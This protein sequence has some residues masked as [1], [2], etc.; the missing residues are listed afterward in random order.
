M[1]IYWALEVAGV[2]RRI[3]SGSGDLTLGGQTYTGV[4]EVVGITDKVVSEGVADR[5]VSF[6]YSLQA[7]Q[8]A[9]AIQD[10]GALEATVRYLVDGS[11][12]VAELPQFRVSGLLNGPRITAGVYTVELETYGSRLDIEPVV[13]SAAAQ[14][15]RNANDSSLD[16]MT[17]LG[18]AGIQVRWPNY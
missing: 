9:A 10:I 4:G 16:N 11:S 17:G 14:R 3:W 5:R 7:N 8:F 6:S 13:W 15:A 1:K 2:S 12:G 18:G